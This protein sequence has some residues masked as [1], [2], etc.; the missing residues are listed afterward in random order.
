MKENMMKDKLKGSGGFSFT[1][2]L[3][4]TIIVGL[5]SVMI[6]AGV[7]AAI[8]TYYKVTDE[9][10]AQT[11]LSTCIEMLR[12][13]L[14]TANDVE[15]GAEGS[16]SLSYKRG[17]EGYEVTLK[18]G[19]TLK[20]I[21]ISS[22]Y[23]EERQLISDEAATNGLTVY[24]K[25]VDFKDGYVTVSDITVIKKQSGAELAKLSELVIRCL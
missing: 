24:F 25:D 4:T 16:A 3:V 21:R 14:S 5:I 11:L 15:T 10:N 2:L 20:S 17:Q 9:A 13:E 23:E 22:A 8:R 12:G 6:A 19:E 7:G 1:E 18:S